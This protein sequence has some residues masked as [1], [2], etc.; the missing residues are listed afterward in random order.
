MH[1]GNKVRLDYSAKDERIEIHETQ[2]HSHF[3]EYSVNNKSIAYH[4]NPCVAHLNTFY[5]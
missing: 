5:S 3:D 4:T 1:F 2:H